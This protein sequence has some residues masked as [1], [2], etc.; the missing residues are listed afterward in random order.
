MTS[1]FDRKTSTVITL[2]VL[3]FVLVYFMPAIAHLTPVPFYI[4]EPIRIMVLI[5]VVVLNSK[6]NAMFLALTLPLFSYILASHPLFIKSLLISIEMVC[7]VIVYAALIKRINK[8]FWSLLIS[9]IAS[10]LFYYLLKFGLIS[11]GLLSMSLIST[12]LI[13]QFI[14]AVTTA[15]LFSQI[16]KQLK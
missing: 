6:Y 14:V 2:D 13:V 15:G 8:P 9:I 12:S 16:Q 4:I 1:V 7:N 3:A 5:S 10:K 11:I